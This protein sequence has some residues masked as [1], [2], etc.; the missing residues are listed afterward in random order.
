MLFHQGVFAVEGNG[1][2]VQIKGTPPAKPESLL[3]HQTTA[4]STRGY[5]A[6][7]IRQ[8][9]SVR[10]DRLGITLSPANRASPSSRT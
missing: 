8:L 10:K 5:E 4:A 7:S 2:E 1:M 6:G 9:Y 3:R